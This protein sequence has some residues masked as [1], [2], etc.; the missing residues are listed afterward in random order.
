MLHTM[1]AHPIL[2][3]YDIKIEIYVEIYH[4]MNNIF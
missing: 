2:F 3:K 1:V 4:I